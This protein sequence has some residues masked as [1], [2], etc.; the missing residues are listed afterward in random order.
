VRPPPLFSRLTEI[1][2][3][4][5]SL[6]APE[7]LERDTVDRDMAIAVCSA[8]VGGTEDSREAVEFALKVFRDPRMIEDLVQREQAAAALDRKHRAIAARNRATMER[9]GPIRPPGRWDLES[10]DSED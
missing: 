2:D 7:E 5:R 8:I 9:P 1:H 4:V 6:L 10:P 3:R